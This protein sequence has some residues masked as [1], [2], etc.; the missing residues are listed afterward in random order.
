MKRTLVRYKT[1]PEMAGENAGLIEKVFAELHARS[2]QGIRYLV[3]RLD[4][5]TFVHFATVD[6]PHGANPLTEMETFRAFQ[7]GVKERCIEPPKS[8]EAT[9]VGA[10]RIWDGP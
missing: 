3:V 5:G 2:P 6:A 9:V 10:Y 7:S 8:A 4:D 1:K